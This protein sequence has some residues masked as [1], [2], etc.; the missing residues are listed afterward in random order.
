M[1]SQ[2]AKEIALALITRFMIRSPRQA[3]NPSLTT[4]AA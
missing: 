4:F 1:E 3:K 2:K